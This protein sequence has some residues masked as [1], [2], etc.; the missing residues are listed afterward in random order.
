MIRIILHFF[1]FF[2]TLDYMKKKIWKN[3]KK[4]IGIIIVFILGAV[5]IWLLVFL[6]FHD[7]PAASITSIGYSDYLGTWE[8]HRVITHALGGVEGKT[9]TNSIDALQKNYA[10]GKRIFEA[11]F[12]L[13]RDGKVILTHDFQETENNL[14]DFEE[15]YI[16]T[17]EEFMSNRI[18]YKFHPTDGMM[19]LTFMKEH[20]DMYLV[21]DIKYN[22]EQPM[23]MV[24]SKIVE[25]AKAMDAMEV[26]DRFIVQFYYEE[27]YEECK[28]IYPFRHYIYSLYAEKKKTPEDFMAAALFCKEHD[29]DAVLI[30]SSWVKEDTT[31]QPF[32]D[33]G[34]KVYVY[35]LNTI[36]IINEKKDLGVYGIV[37]DYANE[38]D[39]FLRERAIVEK[40]LTFPIDLVPQK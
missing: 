9:Y 25:E 10:E 36:R 7:A 14:I 39:L 23:V 29:V 3:R 35:T 5:C 27:N 31:L 33:Q 17:Y 6:F 16:P 38:N 21:S 37:S 18:D 13:T 30:K 12:N 4:V 32:H 11:D 20:P 34:I 24:L 40:K 28:N 2:F 19:L 22:E 15:G 1:T 26:L 8:D